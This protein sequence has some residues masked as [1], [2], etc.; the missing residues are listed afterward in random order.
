MRTD[1]QS[2][3]Y[4]REAWSRRANEIRARIPVS[5]VVG[6][7][8]ELKKAGREMTG[9]C[10]FHNERTP[11]F[12]V[13]D[14][15]GFYHCFGCGAHG[16]AIDFVRQRQGLDF[17]AAVEL[18]ESENGLR[19]LQAARPAPPPP[20]ARQREDADKEEAVRRIWRD[21]VALEAGGVVDRYLRG[22]CLVPPAEYGFGDPA[23]NAGWPPAIR[24][25]AAVWHGLEKRR[26]PAMVT[27]QR[28]GDGTL[29]SVHRTY[30]K[31]TGQA[32]TKAGTPR[33]KAMLGDPA[34]TVMLLGPVADRM[35]GGEGIETSLS[36]M[37][38]YKRSGLAFG[39]RA[40]MASVEPPFECSDFIYAAD[41][42]KPHPDPEKSRV[43]ERA[44]WKG[45]RAFGTGRTV[46]V[47]VP[48]L[49]PCVETGDFND[50]L[51]ARLREQ[52]SNEGRPPA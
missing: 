48:S 7:V 45:A 6:R 21:T 29:G 34:G 38:L 16:G 37:Q 13:N 10:P 15:K 39:S 19:S 12:T 1:V 9:L 51:L 35:I 50:V 32:V 44:A 18:L 5:K 40:L 42:N 3:A 46:Q 20:K 25:G 47:K 27:A 33:D 41:R 52:G 22:R 30:L 26:L 43:G 24:Y 36:A 28:R 4:D 2:V 23:V 11:S 8:V 14:G 49:P 31:V 17:K